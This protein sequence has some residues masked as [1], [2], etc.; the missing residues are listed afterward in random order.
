MKGLYLVTPDWDDTERLLDV[1]DAALRGGATLL[2]YRHKTAAPSLRRTQAERLQAL[3][4]RHGCPFIINDFVELCRDVDA[5]GIHVGGTDLA[6]TEVR[7][8]LGPDKIVGASCYGSLQLAREAH[9]AGASYVAFGGFYPSRVKKY[10]VSTPPAIVAEAK[11]EIPLP[12]V[13]IGGMT[14]ENAQPLVAQG[15]DMVAAISS[16]YFAVDPEAAAREFAMLFA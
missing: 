4:R 8:V 10:E 15:A 6:V 11:R 3:C 13:V 7:R 1:T 12:A 16:V 9:A 2:Q 14:R 5:D